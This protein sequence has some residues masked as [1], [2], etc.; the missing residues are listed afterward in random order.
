MQTQILKKLLIAFFTALMLYSPNSFALWKPLGVETKQLLEAIDVSLNDAGS[1]YSDDATYVRA[2]ELKPNGSFALQKNND[3]YLKS[4]RGTYNTRTNISVSFAYA[5]TNGTLMNIFEVGYKALPQDMSIKNLHIKE[6]AIIISALEK[7]KRSKFIQA[8][9]EKAVETMQLVIQQGKID[10][11]QY[12]EINGIR[13][14][15]VLSKNYD[16]LELSIGAYVKST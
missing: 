10:V 4:N 5:N 14:C 8:V 7:A 13:Y 16:K 2:F 12:F 9:Y 3:D 15:V 6:L 1:P 11:P